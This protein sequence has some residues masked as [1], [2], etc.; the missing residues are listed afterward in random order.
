[1][2]KQPVPRP[3]PPAAA[4]VA[5]AT[6]TTNNQSS[7][8]SSSPPATTPKPVPKRKP[9]LPNEIK[10]IL[11]QGYGSLKQMK[12]ISIPRPT[13]GDGEVLVHVKSWYVSYIYLLSY[14]DE[15]IKK[16]IIISLLRLYNN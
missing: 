15:N 16:N 4:A 12:C 13:P 9:I 1:M 14:Q 3:P 11:L 5:I 2:S 7:N 6:N 8:L 10:C